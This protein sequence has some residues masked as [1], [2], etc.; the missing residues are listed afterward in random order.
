[1]KSEKEIENLL[2]KKLSQRLLQEN[3][4]MRYMKE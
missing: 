4:G 3:M 2:N 1:V